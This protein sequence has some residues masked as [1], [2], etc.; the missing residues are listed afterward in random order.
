[1]SSQ[2][3]LKVERKS[4]ERTREGATGEGLG[5]MLLVLKMEEGAMS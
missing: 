5:L 2:G 1:M 4:E 3:S